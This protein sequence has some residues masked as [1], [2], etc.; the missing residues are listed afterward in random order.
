MCRF[1]VRQRSRALPLGD[2]RHRMHFQHVVLVFLCCGSSY[3]MY[4]ECDDDDYEVLTDVEGAAKNHHGNAT[5]RAHND[6]GLKQW[7]QQTHARNV[8]CAIWPLR[9]FIGISGAVT[10]AVPVLVQIP[11]IASNNM[12][13][14][15]SEAHNGRSNFTFDDRTIG[16]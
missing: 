9:R 14:D 6:N 5:Q 15:I 16:S 13:A 2:L 1:G 8:H 10:T 3:F 4:R 12:M 11:F 7:I